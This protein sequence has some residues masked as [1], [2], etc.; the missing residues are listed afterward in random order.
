MMRPISEPIAEILDELAKRMTHPTD[1]DR[2]PIRRIRR[3]DLDARAIYLELTDISETDA[4]EIDRLIRRKA[5]IDSIRGAIAL[6]HGD[7]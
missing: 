2:E 3:E 4:A 5:I 1:P 7:E 6:G